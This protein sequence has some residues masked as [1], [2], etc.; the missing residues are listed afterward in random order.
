VE[1]LDN[2]VSLSQNNDNKLVGKRADS[3]GIKEK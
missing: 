3:S 2:F 1:R